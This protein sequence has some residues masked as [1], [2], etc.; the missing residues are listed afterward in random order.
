MKRAKLTGKLLQS[1]STAMIWLD[2]SSSGYSFTRCLHIASGGLAS[3]TTL[4]LGLEDLDDDT[5]HAAAEVWLDEDVAT[6]GS[7]TALPRGDNAQDMAALDR[8]QNAGLCSTQN[9]LKPLSSAA[10]HAALCCTLQEHLRL[11]YCQPDRLCTI[12]GQHK[13]CAPLPRIAVQLVHQLLRSW[14]D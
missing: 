1:L 5:A 6:T 11:Q 4:L 2:A 10:C 8:M 3:T 9:V 12:S 7:D 14:M 13:T